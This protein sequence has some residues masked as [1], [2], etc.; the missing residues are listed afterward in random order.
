MEGL[1]DEFGVEYARETLWEIMLMGTAGEMETSKKS[2]RGIVDGMCRENILAARRKYE[3]TKV[4]GTKGGRPRKAEPLVVAEML[5]NG[6]T[7]QEIA[8]ELDCSVRTVERAK[9]ECGATKLSDKTTDRQNLNIEK[10]TELEVELE[11]ELAKELA[12]YTEVEVDVD[13][14]QSPHFD[15]EE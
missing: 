5:E 13:S 14:I 6:K 11:Y 2:I 10:E 1:Q 4:D 3:K 7:K 12:L 9:A 15:G 8:Q